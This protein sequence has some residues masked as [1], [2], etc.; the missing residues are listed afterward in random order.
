[1]PIPH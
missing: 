1:M